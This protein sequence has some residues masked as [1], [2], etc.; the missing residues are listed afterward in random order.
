MTLQIKSVIGVTGM[1]GSGKSVFADYA[2]ELGYETVV[3]GDVIRAKVVEMGH[4]PTPEKT[5][6]VMV[7]LREEFGED[8]VALLTCKNIEELLKSGKEKIVI[9][10]IRSQKEVD[11]FREYIGKGFVI[12]AIHVDP[13][14]RFMRLKKRGRKDAPQSEE[15]FNKRDEIEL[16]VGLGDTIALSNHIISN[17]SNLEIFKEQ[18]LSLL[19]YLKK[20]D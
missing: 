2:N 19:E 16:S 12:I 17:N 9:D 14:I 3:M 7:Q 11:Y 13:E 15:D 5:N 1:P 18:S 8:V 4:E 20:G 10:G 6:S